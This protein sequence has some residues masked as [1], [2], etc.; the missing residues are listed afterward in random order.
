MNHESSSGVPVAQ[1][2]GMLALADILL[3]VPVVL[4]TPT[5]NAVALAHSSLS[6]GGA[7]LITL[8][9]K[10]DNKIAIQKAVSLYMVLKGFGRNESVNVRC[11]SFKENSKNS[12]FYWDNY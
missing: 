2:I 9:K 12:N 1:P 6:T 5:V 7:E 11:S 3:T 4:V 10:Q 8:E